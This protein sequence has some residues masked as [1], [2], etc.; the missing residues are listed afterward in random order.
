VNLTVNDVHIW[1]TQKSLIPVSALSN[2]YGL[3]DDA[4]R[5]RNQ[6]FATQA[7][8]DSDAI[9]RALQRTVLSHYAD[10]APSAWMFSQDDHGKP[11]IAAPHTELS[12][13]LS[14]TKEWVV[15]AVALHPFIGVDVEYCERNPRILS[16]AERFFSGR[17]CQNIAGLPSEQ[18]KSRFFDYWTLKESY[19]KARGEGISLGL[20]RFGFDLKPTGKIELH[21]DSELQDKPELWHFAL[22]ANQGDHRM[23]LAIK[24]AESTH[25]LNI[26]HFYT[27]PLHSTEIYKGPLLLRETVG[28]GLS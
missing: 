20:S 3:M 11:Y 7:M 16:L 1:L 6:R 12:F 25:V 8:R 21:C 18:Q 4:Q 10:V 2:Y 23:A 24:S 14:H 26:E 28:S 19:I 27:I 13:N 15:C 17:E 22:S 5:A 9:T